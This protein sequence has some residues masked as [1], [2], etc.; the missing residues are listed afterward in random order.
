VTYMRPTVPA[1][2]F[3][4]LGACTAKRPP[5]P[6]VTAAPGAQ[7]DY[8][9]IESG[10]RLQIVA[11]VTRDGTGAIMASAAADQ[12]QATRTVTMKASDNLIGY[13]TAFWDVAARAGGGIQ[14]ILTKAQMTRDGVPADIPAPTKAM[15][16]VP[17]QARFL[18][19]FYLI[20][21]SESDHEMVMGGVDRADRLESFTTELRAHPT[22]ACQTRSHIYCEW[23]PYGMAV[24]P[25]RKQTIDG[26][27]RWA[28]IR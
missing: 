17:K 5:L 6:A 28:P 1:I 2:L 24:R 19:L 14:L 13:E 20:R 27:E 18:R 8:V 12:D 25:E 22:E 23:I 3:L 11:P 15:L 9:D 4:M 16:H 26:V 21:K 7:P 10:W